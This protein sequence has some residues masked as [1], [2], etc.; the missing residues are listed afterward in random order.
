MNIDEAIKIMELEQNQWD[1]RNTDDNN[2]AVNL[3]IEALKAIRNYRGKP[4]YSF[5]RLLPGETET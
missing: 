1:F 5:L 3:A 2:A 4:F